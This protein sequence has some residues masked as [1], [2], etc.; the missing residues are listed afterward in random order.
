MELCEVGQ[1]GHAL[2]RETLEGE[3]KRLVIHNLKTCLSRA[4][5]PNLNTES[6]T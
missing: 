2:G 4:Q 3:G 1:Q 6:A 5:E